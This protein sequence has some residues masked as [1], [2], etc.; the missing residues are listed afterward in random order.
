MIKLSTPLVIQ[1]LIGLGG[2]FVFFT[3]IENMGEAAL[4]VSI[5]LKWLYQ[6]IGIPA[7]SIAS[8]INSVASN[9]VGQKDFDAT[10]LSIKRSVLLS[11][12]FTILVSLLLLI[13]PSYIVGVFTTSENIINLAVSMMPLLVFISL[14]SAV[15]SVLFNGLIG[16]GSTKTSLVIEIVGVFSYLTYAYLVVNIF[17]GSLSLVWCSEILYWTILLVF[18]LLYFKYGSWREI[19]V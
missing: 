4:A 16:V 18:S 2:W 17:N 14:C 12:F 15:S 3:F 1:F 13:V 5:V 7:W 19:D 11:I 6:F 8:S 10:V 9:L